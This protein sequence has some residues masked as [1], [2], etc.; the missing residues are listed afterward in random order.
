M[1]G[2]N[3]HTMKRMN[4]PAALGCSSFK[5]LDYVLEEMFKSANVPA[6]QL[7]SMSSKTYPK[8]SVIELNDKFVLAMAVPGLDKKDISVEL[9]NKTNMLTI[10]G[11][12]VTLPYEDYTHVSKNELHL[13]NFS[14]TWDVEGDNI[15][16]S[17]MDATL[18]DGM[19]YVELKKKE[20]DSAKKVKA[21]IK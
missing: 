9:D 14:R 20:A 1:N 4:L 16:N 13:G 18:K 2:Q 8:V 3:Y 12:K 19:L 21:K 15:D 10:E 5:S 11:E 17:S 7:Q 6:R